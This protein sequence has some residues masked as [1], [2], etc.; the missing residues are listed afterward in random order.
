MAKKQLKKKSLHHYHDKFDHPDHTKLLPKLNRVEG[1]IAGIKKMI[2]ERRY[3]P[4]IIQQIR[5]TRKALFGIESNL[6]ERHMKECVTE[7]LET[8]NFSRREEKL[9]EIMQIFK[10]AETQ[11][12]EF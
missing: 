3:C 6:L 5:A 12:I 2:D 4:E 11:G 1:Q 7:A 10:S 9:F 8:K